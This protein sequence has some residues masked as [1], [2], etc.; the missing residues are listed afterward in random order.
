MTIRG[1]IWVALLCLAGL[2]SAV[3][4]LHG[5][6]T[7]WAID[8]RQDPALTW[9][10][11]AIPA[12][13]FPVFLLIRPASRSTFVLS[14][15]ALSYLGVYSILNWRTCSELGYCQSVLATVLQ[16]L[17]TNQVLAFFGVVI[18]NLIALL[19]DDHRSIWG[20]KK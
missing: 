15:M 8:V 20:Y 4:T 6:Y 7:F 19:A 9:S 10:Y 2:L 17:S 5:V 1:I 14:L 13:C 11:C 16:T 18:L 12:L 3:V